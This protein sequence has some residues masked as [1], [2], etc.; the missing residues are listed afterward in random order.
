M[1]H[2]QTI[3]TDEPNDL[4]GHDAP[5]ADSTDAIE[6]LKEELASLKNQLLRRA[7]DMDN[8]RKRFARERVQLFEDALVNA[9]REFLPIHD[10]LQRAVAAADAAEMPPSY[11]DGVRMVADKFTATLHRYGMARIE[12]VGVPFDVNLH[13][14]LMRQTPT[15][16]GTEPN[17]VMSILE[18]GYRL[19]D[20]VIRHA[21]VIVSE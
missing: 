20:R 18:P 14:A 5:A 17:T 1:M 11:S 3:G 15:E 12:D 4:L 9:L 10:D 19:G 2:N 8:M 21:K 6:P 7:A 16:E 13:E